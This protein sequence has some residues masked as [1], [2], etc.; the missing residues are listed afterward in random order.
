MKKIVLSA[1]TIAFTLNSCM[2]HDD[3]SLNQYNQD[4]D[5]ALIKENAQ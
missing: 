1:L 3:S 2:S 4:Q 5:D